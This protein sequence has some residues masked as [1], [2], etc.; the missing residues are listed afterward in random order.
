MEEILTGVREVA[1]DT[2][3]TGFDPAEG[4]R[5][6]EIGAIEM[7]DGKITGRAFHVYVNPGRDMPQGAFKVH[8]LSEMFLAA[9]PPFKA[10]I[11]PFLDFLGES[12][13]VI[14]NAAFDLKFINAELAEHGRNPLANEAVDTLVMTRKRFPGAPATLDALCRKFGIDSKSVRSVH[15]ALVDATLLA[16]V[17]Q[18][19]GHAD[20]AFALGMQRQAGFGFTT[21][22]DQGGRRSNGQDD[23]DAG[24]VA[25]TVRPPRPHLGA[26][27]PD[28]VAA[29]A[30]F[31]AKLKAPVW[32]KYAPVQD[33]PAA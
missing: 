9:M 15:G 33:A 6:A 30:A 10:V 32:T 13:L 11:R 17:Y 14:H 19:L 26:P 1:L 12:R 22:V 29:F 20:K 25:V 3:T 24:P 23:P 28:E 2:E 18:H 7:I 16:R 4:H 27:H 8:G 21:A 31:A 5:L